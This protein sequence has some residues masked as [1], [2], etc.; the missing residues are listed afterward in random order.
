MNE[1]LICLFVYMGGKKLFEM[2]ENRKT[3]IKQIESTS[4]SNKDIRLG[5]SCYQSVQKLLSSPPVCNMNI[6]AQN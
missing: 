5:K 6:I 2:W 1:T 4:S 3:T